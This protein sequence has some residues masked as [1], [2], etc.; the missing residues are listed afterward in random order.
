[1]DWLHKSIVGWSGT[2]WPRLEYSMKTRP[3]LLS[4]VKFRKTSPQ[5]QWKK[6]GM[7]PRILPCVPLPAP[8]APNR[9]IVRYFMRVFQFRIS[10]GPRDWFV[11]L[12][13]LNAKLGAVFVFKLNF[14]NFR[15]RNH[16]FF[17]RVTF[18]NLRVKVVGGNPRNAVYDAFAARTFNE[19]NHVFVRV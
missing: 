17:R 16:H 14:L 13:Q 3:I 4:I 5:A 11:E 15:E 9:R 18:A 10:A 12:V 19:Q 2:S 7:V 1:M 8:G 6:C